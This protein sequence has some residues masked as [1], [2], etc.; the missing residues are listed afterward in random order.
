MRAEPT[1]AELVLWQELRDRQLGVRFRRHHC[2]AHY[3]VD[4][5]SRGAQLAVELDGP[6]HD[7][8]LGYDAARDMLLETGGLLVLRFRNDEVRYS[9]TSVIAR[10]Q[11]AVNDRIRGDLTP[12]PSP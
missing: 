4:F 8:Q 5:Y 11:A 9:L 7:F 3:I 12:G 10:I 2:L 1:E 6:V